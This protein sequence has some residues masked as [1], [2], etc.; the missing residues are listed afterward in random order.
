MDA[1]YT[2]GGASLAA[3]ITALAASPAGA[4]AAGEP[5]TS[6]ASAEVQELIVTAQRREESANRIG[7][8]I[9]ALSGV[10][11]QQARIQSSEDL[12]GVVPGL[13]VARG[14]GVPIYTL[15]GVGFNSTNLSSTGT[16]GTYVDEV[17][18]PY[19]FMTRGPLFDISRVEVLKGPQGTLYGQNTTGGLIDV[20]TN[21]PSDKFGA[22]AKAEFGDYKTRN[23]EGFL[24]LPISDS[25]GARLAFRSEDSDE[26]WQRSFTRPGETLGEVHRLGARASVAWR[27]TDKLD[28]L[29]TANYW[30]DRSDT[31]AGQFVSLLPTSPAAFL[32]PGVTAFAANF[33][34]SD[35]KA[36]DWEPASQRNANTAFST[37]MPGPLA[38][39]DEF[40]GLAL[41]ATYALTD[42][43][44]IVSLTGYSDLKRD[45]ANDYGGTP[46]EES[47]QTRSTGYARVFS[48]ETRLDGQNG[49]V[50]W[51]AG[52]Y[53]ERDRTYD[54]IDGFAGQ[55]AVVSRLRAL[56]GALQA[57]PVFNPMHYTL[58]QIQESFRDYSF[59]GRQRTTS[60]SGFGSATWDI[61]DQLSLTTGVRYTQNRLTFEGGNKDQGDGNSVIMWNT[62][63]R[64]LIM[65]FP[66]P[67]TR[68]DPGL[69]KPGEWNTFNSTTQR[70]SI[71][72]IQE[73]L[74][75]DPVTWRVN[76]DYKPSDVTLLYG[77]VS[78]GIK[79]GAVPVI[80][81]SSDIQLLPARQEVLIAY[82]V[83]VKTALLDRRVQADLNGFYYDYTDK[84]LVSYILDPIF[85][86]LQRL[87]NVPK[88]R[89]YGL[90]GAVT[91]RPDEH[92]TVR[93][94]GTYVNS[95]ITNFIGFTS[96]GTTVD[97]KD[98]D[99]SFAPKY[100]GAA[101]VA[102]QVPISG[103]MG[104]RLTANGSYQSESN[105][106]LIAKSDPNGGAYRINAYGLLNGAVGVYSLDGRWEAELWAQNLTD[107]HY[108]TNIYK[109]IDNTARLTGRP[110]TFGVRISSQF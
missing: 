55:A 52:V 72:P 95:K 17:V 6:Q 102:Y 12:S 61:S 75:Q 58:A 90:D 30:R 13:T 74:A 107:T 91:W 96:V 18:Y 14:A 36:A 59:T 63:I 21:K 44:S 7:M 99:F 47:G 70:F 110:R 5:H 57:S 100:Q 88:S 3:L 76:L 25:L 60:W 48:H 105:A 23:F 15:R 67:V 41:H 42:H 9:T 2:F 79:S 92:L 29:A 98:A 53:Y 85:T 10:V 69:T 54:Q 20:I 82:Q 50:R 65:G 104:A 84:Q 1:R 89:V 34:G 31:Q 43:L 26:G 40:T 28:V 97:F 109:T 37:G 11:L 103:S 93:L 71:V 94:S 68:P 73:S 80:A 81:A 87:V 83:G 86:A 56:G 4:Q 16:V 39:N 35:N 45:D 64:A 78:R 46:Y 32:P 24:N 62:V 101:Q 77:S 8:A 66:G 51:L 38:Y 33:R 106:T 22:G 49:P 27:P 19:P 108:W